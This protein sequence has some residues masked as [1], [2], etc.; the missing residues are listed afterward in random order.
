MG[1]KLTDKSDKILEQFKKKKTQILQKEKKIQAPVGKMRLKHNYTFLQRGDGTK[2]NQ[3]R[4]RTEWKKP[5]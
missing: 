1:N 4:A 3:V 2:L 5:H